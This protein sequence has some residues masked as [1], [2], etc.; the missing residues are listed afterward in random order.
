[1]TFVSDL[2]DRVANRM[3][4]TSDGHAAYL[5]AVDAAFADQVDYAQLVKHYGDGPAG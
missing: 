5:T 2:D 4:V 1:M 3:Q